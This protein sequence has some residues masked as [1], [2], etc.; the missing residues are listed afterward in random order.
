M[1][2]IPVLIRFINEK[3]SDFGLQG[4]VLTI[5][6]QEVI[7][8]PPQFTELFGQPCN[9]RKISD[10]S[11]LTAMGAQSVESLEYL[12]TQGADIT[13]D[14]NE[15]FDH[16]DLFGAFDCVL[17]G[18]TCEHVFNVA[19]C[20]TTMARL[21][22]KGGTIIHINPCLGYFDHGFYAFQPTFYFDFYGDN[23]FSDCE[24]WLFEFTQPNY[25]QYPGHARIMA[26]QPHSPI[27]FRSANNTLVIF[28]ARKTAD[29][30]TTI[31]PQQRIYRPTT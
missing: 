28:K 31:F 10:S 25:Y 7:L 2:M 29:L 5:G 9:A 6:R 24:A 1:A 26:L 13:C 18:G 4:R 22:R 3:S 14:L 30:E 23:G 12:G 17:D 27:N 11:L 20:F 16:P 15:P 8:T 21:V 19:E